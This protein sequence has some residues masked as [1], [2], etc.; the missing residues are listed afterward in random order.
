[1]DEERI[2]LIEPTLKLRDAFLEMAEEFQAA[3][4]IYSHHETARR[5]F[6]VFMYEL[7]SMANER[8]LPSAIVPMTT[9]WLVRGGTQI[10]G[11]S[12]LRHSLTPALRIEG[13]HIGYAIRPS[14]RRKGYGTCILALT[15]EKARAMG[16]ERVLVTCDTDNIASARII[17][18]NGG[19]FSGSD[20]S[21]HS[22]KQ[23]SQYWIRIR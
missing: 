4:E 3:R 5:N 18:K 13:G 6:G 20:I 2:T 14:A 12:R 19:V 23:V 16:L 10:L 1:M 22:G 21:P 9:Y 15:L 17:E 11:E 8:N 7:D